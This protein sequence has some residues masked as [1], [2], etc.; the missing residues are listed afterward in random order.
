[1]MYLTKLKEKKQKK[2]FVKQ[3]LLALIACSFIGIHGSVSAATTVDK[4]D[5]T[6]WNGTALVVQG[7]TGEYYN[8]ASVHAHSEFG[9]PAGNMTINASEYIKIN[10]SGSEYAIATDNFGSVLVE[11]PTITINDN[12]STLYYLY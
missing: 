10:N 4:L 11:A 5:N 3:V 9:D 6:N 7:S 2:I 1:M 12:R 8:Y